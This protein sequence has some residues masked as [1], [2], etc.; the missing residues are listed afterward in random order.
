MVDTKENE[1]PREM[2]RTM[3]DNYINNLDGKMF[4]SDALLLFFTASYLDMRNEMYKVIIKLL[5]TAR[6][7]V[8]EDINAKWEGD[9][10]FYRILKMAVTKENEKL[11]ELD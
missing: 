3:L 10:M 2:V 4:I 1:D 11:N 8:A 6:T 7:A 5:E 9:D